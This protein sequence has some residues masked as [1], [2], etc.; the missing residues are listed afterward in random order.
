MMKFDHNGMVHL[1]RADEGAVWTD[2]GE[3]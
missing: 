3:W 2:D 1:Y